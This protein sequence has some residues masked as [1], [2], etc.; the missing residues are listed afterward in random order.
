[1]EIKYTNIEKLYN[2]IDSTDNVGVVI[3]KLLTDLLYCNEKK[4]AQRIM[5]ELIKLIES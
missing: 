5:N 4:N 2:T 1:M 3:N